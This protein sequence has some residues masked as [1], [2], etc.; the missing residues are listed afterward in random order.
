MRYSSRLFCCTCTPH[1]HTHT[2]IRTHIRVELHASTQKEREGASDGEGREKG[3]WEQRDKDTQGRREFERERYLHACEY[4]LLYICT[5]VSYKHGRACMMFAIVLP[6][7]CRS[8]T[9]SFFLFSILFLNIL[10]RHPLPTP[11]SPPSVSLLP[12]LSPSLPFSFPLL[13]CLS[14]QMRWTL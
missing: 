12:S 13:P 11:L 2:H 10:L 1:R 14:R 9:F 8:P 7:L 4:S 3:N 6:L 5:L